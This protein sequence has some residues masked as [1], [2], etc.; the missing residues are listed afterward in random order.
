MSASRRF[1]S[2]DFEIGFAGR[3]FW[4]GGGLGRG[5]FHRHFKVC[6]I[7]VGH[8]GFLRWCDG[9]MSGSG[10]RDGQIRGGNQS[11]RGHHGLRRSPYVR[12]A[13]I[14]LL[15]GR[16]HTL[17]EREPSFFLRCAEGSIL[18]VQENRHG[19]ICHRSLV[20]AARGMKQRQLFAIC[21]GIII[22]QPGRVREVVYSV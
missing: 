12:R 8:R 4:N 20:F 16:F 21:D 5:L 13:G 6:V 18:G 10:R 1:L 22:V 2:G 9:Q 3:R 14:D 17:L 7:V 11:R 15:T 19:V